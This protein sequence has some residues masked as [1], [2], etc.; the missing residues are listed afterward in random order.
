MKNLGG[1]NYEFSLPEIRTAGAI[2]TFRK[3]VPMLALA[4]IDPAGA[5]PDD[6]WTARLEKGKSYR[7][8][9]QSACAD[10]GRV[11]LRA[12]ADWKVEPAS[13][14]VR[15][16]SPGTLSEYFFTVT[17]PLESPLYQPN[18]TCPLLA[19]TVVDGRRIAVCNATVAVE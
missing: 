17:P 8:K 16:S 9:V 2:Y 12:F 15:P 4:V 1:G 6:P 13:Q 5:V 14:P 7:V 10:R 11:E 3:P 18:E 19:Q